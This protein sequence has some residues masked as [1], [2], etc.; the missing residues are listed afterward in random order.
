MEIIEGSLVGT[1]VGCEDGILVGIFDGCFVGDGKCESDGDI[2][3]PWAT[4]L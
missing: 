1:L 4:Y 3:S 2:L